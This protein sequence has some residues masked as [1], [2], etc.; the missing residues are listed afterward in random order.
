MA[1][2]PWTTKA[3]R[4]VYRNRWIS[5][6]E[7]VAEMPDGRET[8]Y[9]VITT[10]ECVGVL[11]FLDRDTV[12]MTHQY[13]YVSK[14]LTWEMPTGAMDAG[15]AR[16]AAANR[17]LAEEVGYRAG[18][19]TYL[20]SFHS[21]KSVMDE[22]CHLF[23]GEDLVPAEAPPDETE[24]IEVKTF[25]FDEVLRMVTAGEITDAMTVI[26]VLEAARRRATGR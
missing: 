2:R 10:G 26:A 19:L 3:S 15:E 6:R 13:R 16:E 1:P 4:E 18:R 20:T 12:V 8:L 7:D 21:N 11:P 23:I 22:T 14:R 5:V 25:P 17:E 9:G 24:F